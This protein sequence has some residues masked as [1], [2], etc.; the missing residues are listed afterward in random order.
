MCLTETERAK[1][2]VKKKK[3]KLPFDG[4]VLDVMNSPEAPAA[5]SRRWAAG[6]GSSP[7]GPPVGARC[8]GGAVPGRAA[9]RG[10]CRPGRGERAE[11][12]SLTTRRLRCGFCLK[13]YLGVWERVIK[14]FSGAEYLYRLQFIM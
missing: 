10:G 4:S 3:K 9:V 5:D 6:S 11:Q 7:S 12:L 14:L 13:G 1:S 8:N 2:S